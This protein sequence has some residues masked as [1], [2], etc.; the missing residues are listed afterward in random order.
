M[1]SGIVFDKWTYAFGIVARQSALA[2]AIIF[3]FV[4]QNVRHLFVGI[5]NG[6]KGIYRNQFNG[7]T[8]FSRLAIDVGDG[9]IN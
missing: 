8:S 7:K 5:C 4:V 3:E 9:R 6:W 2:V 1:T